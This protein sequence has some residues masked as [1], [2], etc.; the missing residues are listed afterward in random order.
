MLIV[1]ILAVLSGAL[2]FGIQEGK[3]FFSFLN[4]SFLKKWSYLKS[5]MKFYQIFFIVLI[6][7]HLCGILLDKF[8]HKNKETLNSIVTG[9]K[10]TSENESIK[11]NIYQ[12][13][14]SL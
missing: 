13:M 3:E 8:L 11:L 12:K 6:I 4:D 10:I 5:Y 14:F 9:Y 1:A 7:A 2:L